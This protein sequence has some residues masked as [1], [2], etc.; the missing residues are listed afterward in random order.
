MRIISLDQFTV[1][2]K[3]WFL[4]KRAYL[5]LEFFSDGTWNLIENDRY[6]KNVLNKKNWVLIKKHCK[7]IIIQKQLFLID[8][9]FRA[10]NK[11][12]TISKYYKKGQKLLI[13]KKEAQE[14]VKNEYYKL[15][16]VKL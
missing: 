1:S 14:I 7:E 13:S 4:K 15:F 6:Q 8:N 2:Y 5:R 16:E 12:L 10:K 9:Y 3:V 11:T